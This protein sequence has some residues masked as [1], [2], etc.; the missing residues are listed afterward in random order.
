MLGSGIPALGLLLLLQGSADGNG[1]QGFFY[2]WSCEGDIWDRESCGGQA[3]IESPNLCLRLRCC[4]RDGVCYHQR[5]DENMR[6]KHMWALGWAC[7]G[8]LLLSC[9]ICLFWWAKRRDVLH[10][11]GFLAGQCDLSKSVSLLSKHRGTKKTPSAGSAPVALSKE[12]K[13]A[14]GATEGEGTEEG[15]ETEGEEDED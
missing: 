15:E 4:Y 12:S 3:A 13:D 6:R 9:S 8:L 14:E 2:P 1:I 10:M 7:G 5:P 11:P